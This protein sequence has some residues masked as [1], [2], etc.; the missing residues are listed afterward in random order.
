ME[1]KERIEHLLKIG[2][3]SKNISILHYGDMTDSL[4]LVKIVDKVKLD[5]I[6]N[7][8]AQ[9]YVQASFEVPEYTT[10]MVGTGTLCL[11]EAVR[12]CEQENICKIYQASTSELFGKV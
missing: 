7:L 10:D 9:S 2:E 8:A 5:E 4:S 3:R 6:Y 11:L 1:R 12:I